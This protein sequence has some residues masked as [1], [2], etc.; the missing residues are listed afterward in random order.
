M[1]EARKPESG[2]DL[3]GDKVLKSSQG[4]RLDS[5]RTGVGVGEAEP[6]AAMSPTALLP[7]VT[8]RSDRTSESP[9]SPHPFPMWGPG[10]F[11]IQLRPPACPLTAPHLPWA[12]LG[13]G[14]V[15]SSRLTSDHSVIQVNKSDIRE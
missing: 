10:C 6:G 2:L 9:G 15:V 4:M 5:Y 14:E 13:W 12:H 8:S 11:P 1:P 7:H 3:L